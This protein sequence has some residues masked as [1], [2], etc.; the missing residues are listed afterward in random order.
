[1][2]LISRVSSRTYRCRPTRKGFR[3]SSRTPI[4]KIGGARRKNKESTE[5]SREKANLKISPKPDKTMTT[6]FLATMKC[7][8]EL[9]S[10]QL[11]KIRIRQKVVGRGR[12]LS[13]L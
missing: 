3:L 1:M 12:N 9:D 8:C 10:T 5:Y 4:Y 11:P 7:S 2:G 13:I 6:I